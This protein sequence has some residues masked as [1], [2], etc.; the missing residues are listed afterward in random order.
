MVFFQYFA[1]KVEKMGQGENFQN[2][3]EIGSFW[4][5]LRVFE[6]RHV[7]ITLTRAFLTRF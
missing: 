2:G 7:L 3:V 6:Q 4:A 5:I 1:E